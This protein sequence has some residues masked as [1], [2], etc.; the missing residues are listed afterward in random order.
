MRNAVA[1]ILA[2]LGLALVAAPAHA[3]VIPVTTTA[4]DYD[5]AAPCSLRE[6]IDAATGTG[7]SGC[8]PGSA[9]ADVIELSAEHYVLSLPPNGADD[10]NAG[11]DLDVDDDVTI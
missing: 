2:G 11:G 10:D 8:A 4:D 3:A 1:G 6:A 5:N 7:P 9:G